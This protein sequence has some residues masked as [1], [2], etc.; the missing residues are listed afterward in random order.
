[1]RNNFYKATF[2]LALGASCA[3]AQTTNQNQT[4]TQSATP[5]SPQIQQQT[6]SGTLS[7][8]PL[9]Q[10]Q[11]IPEQNSAP[12]QSTPPSSV[13]ATQA[14][15]R[16]QDA[17]Q[18]QLPSG[19]GKVTVSVSPE[20]KIQLTGSVASEEAKQQ[21][22]QIARSAASD[23]KIMNDLT[24]S[25]SPSA[26]MTAPASIAPADITKASA[27]TSSNTTGS[28]TGTDSQMSNSSSSSNG[29]Q[30]GTSAQSSMTPVKDAS[31][32]GGAN[33]RDS[34]QTA[35]QQEPSLKDANIK[36]NVEDNKI[37]LTG[38]AASNDDKKTAVRV[39]KANA[40]GK[41]VTDHIKVTGPA[42]AKF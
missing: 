15:W 4:T 41:K 14:Q 28:Q 26:S 39:T 40:K 9:P 38:T 23:Q 33:L 32:T 35:L 30:A 25:G 5:Q 13:S 6:P 34:I 18:R 21:A 22:G 36:V 37:E 2:I 27:D 31:S 20:Q 8:S 12:A 10:G 1:M 17:L 3:I 19:A 24:V 11:Q 16:I 7:P 29:I 42:Q